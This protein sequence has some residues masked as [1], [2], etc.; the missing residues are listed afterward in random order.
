[1]TMG[2]EGGPGVGPENAEEAA[3]SFTFDQPMPERNEITF[4][5]ELTFDETVAK[6]RQI[7]FRGVVDENGQPVRPYENAKFSL[8][9][10]YPSARRDQPP[11]VS[12]GANDEALWTPQPTI[13]DNQTQIIER[14]STF[15]AENGKDIFRLS[16]AVDYHWEGR[17]DYTILP[18]LVEM[19]Q[20]P[21]QEGTIDLD[22]FVQR[23][24]GLFLPDAQGTLHD[25]STRYLD[26]FHVDE[27]S[28]ARSFDILDANMGL[29]NYGRRV[30]DAWNYTIICDGA[31]RIDFGVEINGVPIQVILVGPAS[32]EKPLRPY[33]ALPMPFHPTTRL[34]SKKAEALYPTLALDKVHILADL[35]RKVLHYK[36]TQAGLNVSSLRSEQK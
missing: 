21:L 15:L 18:P 8:V 22:A 35:I 10:V 24:D 36:W 27:V 28:S 29:L 1:M 2:S 33:Y 11:T 19:Q 30:T 9:T 26:D 25:M 3:A 12:I 23:F 16:G 5:R 4:A 7:E 17:G 14:V 31:H 32:N 20:L 34:S 6:L 13:Y